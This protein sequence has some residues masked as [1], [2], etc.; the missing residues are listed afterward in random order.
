MQHLGFP[1][2]TIIIFILFVAAALFVDL[3]GHKNDKIMSLKSASLWSIFWVL[4]SVVFW[5][6]L[7]L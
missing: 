4:V 7:V 3:V 2:Y 6:F 1:L 5:G